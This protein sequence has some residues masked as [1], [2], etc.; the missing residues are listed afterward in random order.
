MHLP[1]TVTVPKALRPQATPTPQVHTFLSMQVECPK[2]DLLLLVDQWLPNPRLRMEHNRVDMEDLLNNPPLAMAMLRCTAGLLVLVAMVVVGKLPTI[3]NGLSRT[4]GV[5][6]KQVPTKA[7]LD[8]YGW[9]MVFKI[10]AFRFIVV[11]RARLAAGTA[12]R[13]RKGTGEC[14]TMAQNSAS[15]ANQTVV[16]I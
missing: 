10:E 2:A 13:T 3:N 14:S 16:A 5:S 11:V 8:S 4:L 1:K 12:R 9:P 7:R 15:S 6:I